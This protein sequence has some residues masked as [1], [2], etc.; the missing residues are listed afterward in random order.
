MNNL[1]PI[2]KNSYP[3][4]VK[5]C[6]NDGARLIATDSSTEQNGPQIHNP[7]EPKIR[8]PFEPEKD[9][10]FERRVQT[11]QTYY[12][13]QIGNR[14]AAALLDGLIFVG[15]TIPALIAF[16]FAFISAYGNEEE[17]AI[18]LCVLGA[19]L[20]L[21]PL[22]FQLAKDGFGKG[23]SPGKKAMKL[24]VIDLETNMPCNKQKSF[25][26]NIIVLLI[27]LVPV[28]GSLIEPIMA[29]A[30][31]DGRRLGDRAANTM[32]IDKNQYFS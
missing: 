23:Q 7:F 4:D 27:S 19:I 14:I 2:C 12:K 31:N 1:C 15:L 11:G 5:F 20:T 3:P 29:L 17:A 26:R 18:A 28:I 22:G 6:I 30:T 32:V 13:A 10:P 25:L 24:M 21:I 9:V 16:L 8:N